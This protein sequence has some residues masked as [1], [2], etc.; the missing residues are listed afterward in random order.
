MLNFGMEPTDDF[1]QLNQKPKNE[2]GSD[3]MLRETPSIEQV[4]SSNEEVRPGEGNNNESQDPLQ[5][6][7]MREFEPDGHDDYHPQNETNGAKNHEENNQESKIFTPFSAL[8]RNA[9]AT[10]LSSRSRAISS[11]LL[12]SSKLTSSLMRGSSFMNDNIAR[13]FSKDWVQSAY[14]RLWVR[15]THYQ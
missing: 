7:K 2:E 3:K 1:I 4:P 11:K 14:S 10:S 12:K 8:Q 5:S 13:R 9:S 15:S 6:V